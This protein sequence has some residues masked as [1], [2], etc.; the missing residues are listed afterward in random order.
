MID[1]HCVCEEIKKSRNWK[2]NHMENAP[3]KLCRYHK[4]I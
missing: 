3:G 2:M 4:Y 1:E